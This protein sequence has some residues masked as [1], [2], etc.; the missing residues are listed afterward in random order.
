MAIITR[1]RSRLP[2]I[3]RTLAPPTPHDL[4][5]Q[6]IVSEGQRER[7]LRSMEWRRVTT[8]WLADDGEDG[9]TLT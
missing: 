9:A 2:Q 8:P 3:Q 7:R 6:R 5:T 1:S 4:E